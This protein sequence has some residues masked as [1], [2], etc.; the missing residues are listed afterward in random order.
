VALPVIA[1]PLF[2]S[3]GELEAILTTL[4]A[5]LRSQDNPDAIPLALSWGTS[6]VLMKVKNQG[7]VAELAA[8]AWVHGA[9]TIAA[10]VTFCAIGGEPVPAS[11]ANLWEEVEK[12]LAEIHKGEASIPDLVKPT[13]KSTGPVAVNI[14]VDLQR[15]RIVRRIDASSTDTPEGYN[16]PIDWG[17]RFR[18]WG[19]M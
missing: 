4:G 11:I 15:A 7:T 1:S 14:R 10:A 16:P 12:D 9:A 2:T 18:G 6:R 5:D 8:S 17:A 13:A 19:W 3:Q